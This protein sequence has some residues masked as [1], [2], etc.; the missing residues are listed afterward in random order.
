MDNDETLTIATSDGLYVIGLQFR[1]LD[2]AR[3]IIQ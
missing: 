2:D 1:S 3:E